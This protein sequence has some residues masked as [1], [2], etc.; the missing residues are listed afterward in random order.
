MGRD[1]CFQITNLVLDKMMNKYLVLGCV[2]AGAVALS[3]EKSFAGFQFTAPVGQPQQQAA[4]PPLSG[5]LLPAVP[6]IQIEGN[7]RTMPATPV[8]AVDAAP[9]P[10]LPA[11]AAP[12][13]GLSSLAPKAPMTPAPITA[14]A[15]PVS[16]SGYDMAVGFGKDLPLV[17]ALRQVVPS[18]YTY[19]L[20]RSVPTSSKVS[21]NGGR[22][23]DRVLDDM[24]MP[25]GLTSA[26]DGKRVVISSGAVADI[27][28]NQ[29]P[30]QVM[31]PAAPQYTPPPTPMIQ[32]AA[33]PA[34]QLT[35]PP[36]R[37]APVST[38]VPKVSRGTW[39]AS[40][41]DSLRGVLE[42]WAG[43]AGAD[44]FWSSD[45]DYPLAGDVNVSG[46]FEEAVQNI[47]RGFEQARPKPVGRLHPN[48]PHGPAV[49]VVETR[50]TLE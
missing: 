34:V 38:I 14:P 12:K 31:T 46:T 28:M 20:D 36:M 50:Q 7:G 13:T 6:D 33:Q 47:L 4:V 45:Y 18:D 32:T 11:P 10:L 17:T 48:L 8:P 25:L 15:S 35:A 29:A 23:W 43:Q 37:E 24:I 49:L 2:F 22:S 26:I 21:W 39:V 27:P 1:L 16:Q 40:R 42:E 41:G 5:A 30:A 9:T 3:A 44:M 19:V